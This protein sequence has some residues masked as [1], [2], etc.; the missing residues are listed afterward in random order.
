M[1]RYHA[2]TD[3]RPHRSIQFARWALFLLTALMCGVVNG[4]LSAFP[5]D[6]T[7]DPAQKDAQNKPSKDEPNDPSE[8]EGATVSGN[9]VLDGSM[10][11]PFDF[12]QL[13]CEL[14]ENIQ[15]E[16]PPLPDNWHQLDSA[17][18][19]EWLKTFQQSD[20]GKA[21]YAEQQKRLESQKKYP[22]DIEPGGAF[23]IFDVPGGEYVLQGEAEFESADVMYQIEVTGFV[24]VDENVE[25]VNL[26]QLPVSVL[27]LLQPGDLAPPF[28]LKDSE[29]KQ[30][31]SD[32]LKGNPFLIVFWASWSEPCRE[33]LPTLQ[34]LRKRFPQTELA[35]V[36]ISVDEDA[37][38][39]KQ[40][41]KKHPFDAHHA[42]TGGWNHPV[43][44]DYAVG[45][46]VPSIWLVDAKGKIALTDNQI[47]L[48]LGDGKSLLDLVAEKIAPPKG[49]DKKR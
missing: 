35:V 39:W 13:K 5:Q 7:Q 11:S 46:V 8:R 25:E 4:P 37:D 32:V 16:P 31:S 21:Y 19:Q 29:Q 45:G 40:F 33:K 30:F 12:Q 26:Q 14:V 3:V 24:S 48:D 23:T 41:L 1:K 28:E 42:Q 44:S 49:N 22:V 27:R 2:T 38:E 6:E 10:E 15:F 43:L 18:R 47:F 9:F 34:E 17:K 36:M 20:E